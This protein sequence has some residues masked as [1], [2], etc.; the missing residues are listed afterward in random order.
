MGEMGPDT[1]PGQVDVWEPALP[2]PGHSPLR[3]GPTEQQSGRHSPE[4][5][6]LGSGAWAR[7]GGSSQP[8]ASS[9]PGT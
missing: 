9:D 2:R 4:A 1:E 3:P 8:G 5:V 7:G 6:E